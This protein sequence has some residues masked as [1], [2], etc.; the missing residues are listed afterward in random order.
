M[1]VYSS[2]NIVSGNSITKDR[3]GVGFDHSDN[4]TLSGNNITDIDDYGITT[5]TS[6]GN[7]IF[8]NNLINNGQHA[9]SYQSLNG[10]DRGYPAGGNYWSDYSGI[11]I[12]SGRYQ[13]ET[14]GDGIGDAPY[15]IDSENTDRYPLMNLW[16]RLPGDINSD[17]I[18]DIY[19]AILLGNAYNSMPGK[20]NWNPNADLNGDNIVDIYD[21]IILAS[22]YNQHSP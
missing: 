1:L 21:A 20:A 3:Q 6:F 5:Y 8:H 13:N 2:D 15:F 10:F 9:E 4:N 18:V 17:A 12:F 11:D 19:D 22:H 7:S 14:G 16:L